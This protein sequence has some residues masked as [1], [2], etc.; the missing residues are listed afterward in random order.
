MYTAPAPFAEL[1]AWL[2]LMPFAALS[3]P[4]APTASVLPSPLSEM[5]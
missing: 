4:I 5:A 2:P 1:S 3:S